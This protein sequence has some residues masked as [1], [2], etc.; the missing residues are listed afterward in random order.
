MIEQ[1]VLDFLK[2]K[3]DVPVYMERHEQEPESFVII[4][5]TGSGSSNKIN[6]AVFAVQSYAPTM[7]RASVLNEQ[8][9]TALDDLIEI[10]VISKSR[11]NS[12][13][14]YTNTTDKKYRYQCVYEITYNKR[15]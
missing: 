12:D 5:M 9:K 10:D 11:L 7:F 14:N 6:N 13:Y 15:G 3:L 4:Q 8:V 2:T 1:I